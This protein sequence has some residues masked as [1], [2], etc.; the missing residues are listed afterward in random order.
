MVLEDAWTENPPP[1]DNDSYS[2]SS[3]SSS[4]PRYMINTAGFSKPLPVF[5]RLFGYSDQFT[6]QLISTR[7]QH[8][9]NVLHRQPDNEEVTAIA[10]WTSKQVSILSYGPVVGIAGGCLRAWQTADTFRFPFFQANLETF[11]KDVFPHARMPWVR[12][13]RAIQAW[14]LLRTFSYGAFGNFFSSMFF[15]SY[16]VSVAAVG[17]ASDKRLKAYVEAVRKI[18]QQRNGKLPGPPGQGQQGPPVPVAAQ[19]QDDASPTGGMYMG[20]EPEVPQEE[21]QWKPSPQSRPPVQAQVPEPEGQPFDAF[22]EDTSTAAQQSAAPATQ[23]SQPRGSAW[24]R[25]RRGQMSGGQGG[26]WDTVRKTQ[27][28]EQSEW[29]KQ[30]AQS[31]RDQKQGSTFGESYSIS[32]TDEERS[33]AKEQAQRE[34]DAQVERERRGEDFAGKK[35]W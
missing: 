28:P 19:G 2:S 35:G 32:K 26:G 25:L 13:N 3:D 5:G 24:E 31:Q 17:E 20:A 7:L 9:A 34:F 10:F 23:A 4:N 8:M 6:A 21:P 29:S 12:G 15:G 14:H 27:G 33:Y 18:G 22:S 11:Q 30:Q 1:S 16:S